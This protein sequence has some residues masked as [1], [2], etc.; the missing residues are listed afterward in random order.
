MLIN[1]KY[2]GYQ[3][4]LASMVYNF[5][6]ENTAGDSVKNGNLWDQ[7]LAEEYTNQS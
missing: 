2:D 5:F 7:Q 3:R 6:D 1:P 4:S